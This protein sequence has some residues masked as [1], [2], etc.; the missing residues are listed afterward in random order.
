[1]IPSVGD[2][3]SNPY[4]YWNQ[5]VEMKQRIVSKV[6]RLL[7]YIFKRE[8]HVNQVSAVLMIFGEYMTYLELTKAK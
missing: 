2:G 7:S 4:F 5:S 6:K 8:S 3:C 1:M